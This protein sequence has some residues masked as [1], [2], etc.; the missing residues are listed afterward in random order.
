MEE[1]H[2]RQ[3]KK[4]LREKGEEMEIDDR[5]NREQEDDEEVGKVVFKKPNGN[6]I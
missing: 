5:E 3:I 6:G 2:L 4:E 1:F